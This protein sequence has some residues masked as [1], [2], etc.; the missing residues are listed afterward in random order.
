MKR[1][2][3]ICLP[4]QHWIAVWWHSRSL[5]WHCQHRSRDA[6]AQGRALSMPTKC[7]KPGRCSSELEKKRK[8]FQ[9]T[10]D[11]TL[12]LILR[13][14]FCTCQK[15]NL[16]HSTDSKVLCVTH[17]SWTNCSATK[18]KSD[19]INIKWNLALLWTRSC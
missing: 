5:S 10:M 18:A 2:H 9:F 16:F 1:K 14:F 13:L 17:C 11:E 7:R 19:R 6:R 4:V 15:T 12:Q 8:I 3:E